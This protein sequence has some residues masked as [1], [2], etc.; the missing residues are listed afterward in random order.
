M[1]TKTSKRIPQSAKRIL[2]VTVKRMLDSDPDTSYLGEYSDTAESE[3]AIDRMHS[4]D[5]ASLE[6]NH[7]STVD[8]LERIISR[9]NEQQ[10]Q[11][12]DSHDEAECCTTSEA[13]DLLCDLQMECAYCDCGGH[14]VSSREYRYFNPCHE[15]YK[16]EPEADIRKYCKQ[17][18][19]RMEDYNNQGWCYL[20]I[21]AMAEI[22]LTDNKTQRITSGGLYGT[23]SDSDESYIKSLEQEELSQLKDELLAMGFSRRAVS[24]AFKSV[25]EVSE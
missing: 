9:L 10:G 19:E 20:G 1:K 25:E 3:Y 17:D 14:K 8:Q 15:N 13:I 4:E 11:A 6:V 18:Y 16:G 2:S 12:V 22:Q 23:E 7:R 24:K 5:C 21:K